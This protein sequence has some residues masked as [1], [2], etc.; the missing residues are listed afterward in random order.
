MALKG[1]KPTPSKRKKLSKKDRTRITVLLAIALTALLTVMTVGMYFLIFM[2]SYVGG[3]PKVN[4]EEYKENQD[5]TTIIYAYDENNEV[6]EL[7]RL[8]GEQ[9][10]VWVTYRENSEDS[11]IPQNLADAYVALEDKRFYKHK[12]VDWFRTASAIFKDRGGT[13]GSTITQQLIKNLTGENKR[14]LNRKFYEILTA[15]NLEKNISKETILEA[16]MNTIYMS[17]GF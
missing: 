2:V 17:H 13:G 11:V 1:R 5:Q 6:L 15:L 14:T 9:N 16:Y 10:R 7:A 12:G 8:H 3:E 4:L